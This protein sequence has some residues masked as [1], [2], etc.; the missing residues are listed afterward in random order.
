MKHSGSETIRKFAMWP[1]NMYNTRLA[2]CHCI[3]IINNLSTKGLKCSAIET[4]CCSPPNVCLYISTLRSNENVTIC[5]FMI[6]VLYC[7][8]V[9]CGVMHCIV[10]FTFNDNVL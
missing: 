6:H 9:S 3:S 5:E 10:L 4:L 7:C 2:I 1:Q 8:A